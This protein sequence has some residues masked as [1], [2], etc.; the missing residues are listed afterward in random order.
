[1]K[2]LLLIAATSATI[3]S[4]SLSFAHTAPCDSVPE[5]SISPSAENQWYLKLNA[6][7]SMFTKQKDKLVDLKLKSNTS[8]TADIGVGYYLM[9]NLRAD[10]SLGTVANA[11]LKKSIIEDGD[12]EKAEHKPTIIALL[13][14]GYVDFVDLGMA[15]IFA[16][17]GVGA[18]SLKEKVSYNIL[19]GRKTRNLTASTKRHYNFS[20]Q[21]SLGASTEVAP[22]VKAELLYKWADFG[23]TKSKKVE[24]AEGPLQI[25]GLRYRG[26]N[27]LAGIRFDI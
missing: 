27:V 2:K 26:H 1:M 6:G 19:E 24:F 12:A 11:K 10:L 22:G 17:A 13:V 7:A 16:G 25:G 5:S 4:S 8:F 21:L 3:L 23:K 18:A 15:K 14:N 20:Y 9:D